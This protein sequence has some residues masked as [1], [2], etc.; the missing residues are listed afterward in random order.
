MA[1]LLLS[2]FFVWLMMVSLSF[3]QQTTPP[4]S[5]ASMFTSADEINRIPV[6]KA[7]FLQMGGNLVSVIHL[8]EFTDL[9]P[10][11]AQPVA[12]DGRIYLTTA[13]FYALPAAKRLHILQDSVNYI[14]L[15]DANQKPKTTISQAYFQSLPQDKQTAILQSGDFIIQ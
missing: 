11:N 9:V 7:S 10:T 1:R 5:G 13:E 15:A 12:G 3:A 14:V 8:Y 2:C 4:S 6:T